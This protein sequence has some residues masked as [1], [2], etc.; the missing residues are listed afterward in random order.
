MTPA[1]NPDRPLAYERLVGVGGIGT[2]LFFALEGAHDL[3]RD[4]S[5]PARLL[6]VRDYCKLHI[7]AHYA[8]VLL[9]ARAEGVPFHVLPVGAVGADEAGRRLRDE[10]SS[11]GM[12]VRCVRDV[13]GRP[14]LLS[15]CFQYPDGSGG[16][17]T[18]SDSAAATLRPEDLEAVVPLLDARTIAV[19][20]PEVPLD[21]RRAL[22][23]LAGRQGALR[24]AAL[25]T[26]DI[27]PARAA[28]LL[29]DMDLLALNAHEAQAL[30]C[31]P[32]PGGPPNP[33]LD[34][35]RR[36]L[37]RAGAGTR[38]IVT[39]GRRGA[40]GLDAGRWSHTPAL[41]VPV[42]STAGAG[43]ALLGG[44]LAGLAAG[45]PFIAPGP[46]PTERRD[47]PFE[48][49][50]DLG[51]LLASFAVTSPHTIHPDA[52]PASLAAFARAHSLRLGPALAR[53]LEP[54]GPDGA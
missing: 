12:D 30:A 10:M 18:T 11:A 7:V 4:E 9:G 39:A 54:G 32:L 2:G 52:S 29:A 43:D 16:N 46:E 13:P 36:A 48:S 5:R 27:E 42:A 28:G 24:V 3:G 35:L 51:V 50:L 22:L 25:A 45:A 38:A 26:A 23:R 33:F 20:L 40:W 19:A 6:D 8:A 17:I 49:A 15:V 53:V 21:T 31:E 44:A 47:R 37:E 34:A 41:E 1:S 14:T